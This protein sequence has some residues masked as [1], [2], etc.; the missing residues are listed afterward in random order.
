MAGT[1]VSASDARSAARTR[2]ISDRM[3]RD[4]SEMYPEFEGSV[5]WERPSAWPLV[6]SVAK[7]QGAVWRDKAPHAGSGVDGLFFVGD[8]TVSYGIGTDSAAHSS[9]LCHPLI[10]RFLNRG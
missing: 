5:L 6:E 8:S 2:G 9:Q 3:R 4:V 7:E 10:V 1:P